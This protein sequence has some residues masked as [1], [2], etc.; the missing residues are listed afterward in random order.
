MKS[1]HVHDK[2][3]KVASPFVFKIFI[4]HFPSQCQEVSLYAS[5]E[6]GTRATHQL[7][8]EERCVQDFLL[9]VSHDHCTEVQGGSLKLCYLASRPAAEP[10]PLLAVSSVAQEDQGG[11]DREGLKSPH[12][13]GKEDN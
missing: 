11:A 8:Q 12:L 5:R 6:A 13:R 7:G 10:N 4:P 9:R 2:T 3:S 1:V